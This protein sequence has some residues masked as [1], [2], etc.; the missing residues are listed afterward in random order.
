MDPH[1]WRGESERGRKMKI[2]AKPENKECPNSPSIFPLPVDKTV[3]IWPLSSVVQEAKTFLFLFVFPL[4]LVPQT[5]SDLI[6]CC[7]CGGLRRPLSAK[8]ERRM[9][10]ERV[11]EK[12]QVRESR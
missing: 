6:L 3:S 10:T 9:R 12:T 5:I 1:L 2:R 7:V 8:V 4:G 11:A